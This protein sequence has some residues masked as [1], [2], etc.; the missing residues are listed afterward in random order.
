MIIPNDH[1]KLMGSDPINS[2]GY[3]F[4]TVCEMEPNE[5]TYWCRHINTVEYVKN[6]R[7]GE[8]KQLYDYS[9]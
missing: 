8:V 7:T 4:Y 9:E 5:S 6:L 2:G 1:L 3:L